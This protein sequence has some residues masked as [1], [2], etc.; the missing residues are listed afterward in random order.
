MHSFF[1][2]WFSGEL[3]ERLSVAMATRC[4]VAVKDA[5]RSMGLSLLLANCGALDLCLSVSVCERDDMNYPV[6]L[7]WGLSR[8][9]NIHAALRTIYLWPDVHFSEIF[10]GC[11]FYVQCVEAY[12]CLICAWKL[13]ISTASLERTVWLAAMVSP[14][15]LLNIAFVNPSEALLSTYWVSFFFWLACLFQR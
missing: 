7:L 6:G 8:L 11:D 4:S 14:E 9:V 3:G 2:M 10:F 15:C 5:A 13:C 1:I 12:L